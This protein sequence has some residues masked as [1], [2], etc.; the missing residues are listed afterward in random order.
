[1]AMVKLYLPKCLEELGFT[2]ELRR[3]ADTRLGEL[4]RMFSYV[5]EAPKFPV[6]LWKAVTC[7]LLEIVLVEH[8]QVQHNQ[9]KLPTS[10]T[11]IDMTVDE[12]RY[13]TRSAVKAFGVP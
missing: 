2:Q 13:L 7:I 8:Q 10:I 4:L 1:M 3:T 9:M 5:Q 12:Y 11:A 6:K